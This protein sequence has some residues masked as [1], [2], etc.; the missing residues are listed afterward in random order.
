VAGQIEQFKSYA[1]RFVGAI[2]AAVDPH[3]IDPETVA[4]LVE[5]A[6]LLLDQ[7]G[8]RHG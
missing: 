1:A 4:A 2:A 5:A 8:A 7:E 6:D 3:E